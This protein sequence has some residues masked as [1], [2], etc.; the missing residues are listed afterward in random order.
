MMVHMEK[1]KKAERLAEDHHFPWDD[2]NKTVKRELRLMMMMMDGWMEE[3]GEV[4]QRCFALA[5]HPWIMISA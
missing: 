2:M 4:G 3:E 1:K 5:Y